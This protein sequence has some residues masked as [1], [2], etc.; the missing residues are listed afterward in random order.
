[1]H[2]FAQVQGK[3]PPECLHGRLADGR[4][5]QSPDCGQA[6]EARYLDPQSRKRL[7]ELQ[8]GDAQ[9]D[10]AEGL[11]QRLQFENAVGRQ[12]MGFEPGPFGR[13]VRM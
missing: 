9:P 12:Q 1:M 2:V 3:I 8:A 13:H 10:D 6:I 5:L 11:R 7:A 4:V